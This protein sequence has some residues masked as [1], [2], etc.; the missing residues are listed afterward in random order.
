MP[1]AE[2]FVDPV[3]TAIGLFLW[4]STMNLLCRIPA[5]DFCGLQ[6]LSM[7]ALG[8]HRLVLV[9]VA[10][11]LVA[12]RHVGTRFMCRFERHSDR[13]ITKLV[14]HRAQLVVGSIRPGARG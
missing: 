4:I 14:E 11:R 1:P 13:Q 12:D 9:F 3:H 2:I 8:D 10:L 7:S 5:R 6:K